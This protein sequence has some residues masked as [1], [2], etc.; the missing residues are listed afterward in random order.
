[1]QRHECN[2]WLFILIYNLIEFYSFQKLGDYKDMWEIKRVLENQGDAHTNLEIQSN[3]KLQSL[4]LSATQSPRPPCFQIDARD[5]CDLIIPCSLYMFPYLF[6]AYSS[7]SP[8]NGID[9]PVP[10]LRNY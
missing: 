8:I 4:I 5:M 3:S 10:P 6:L 7:S 2:K 9:L 1:M